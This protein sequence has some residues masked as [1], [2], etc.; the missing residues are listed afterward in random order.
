MSDD[1]TRSPTSGAGD[2]LPAPAASSGVAIHDGRAVRNGQVNLNELLADA[3]TSLVNLKI[4]TIVG[5]A[6]IT[7]PIHK[8]NVQLPGSAASAVT[9]I[10]LLD[11]DI[12]SC[13][14]PSILSGDYKDMKAVHE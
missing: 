8:P 6:T 11:G 13:I 4:S 1:L 2:S 14:S 10:N 5:E 9:N 3:A 7:G 12:T